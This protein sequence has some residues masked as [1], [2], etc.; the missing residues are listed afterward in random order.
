MKSLPDLAREILSVSEADFQARAYK[1]YFGANLA[2]KVYPKDNRYLN[3]FA[4][5]VVRNHAHNRE[6]GMAA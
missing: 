1:W 3:A 6:I 5:T 2:P 4:Q